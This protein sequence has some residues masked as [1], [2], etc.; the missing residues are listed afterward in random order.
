MIVKGV[1]NNCEIYLEPGRNYLIYGRMVDGHI[2]TYACTRSALL[3]G[4]PDI[5]YLEKKR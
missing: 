4:N 1:D 3:N 5:E 2:Y